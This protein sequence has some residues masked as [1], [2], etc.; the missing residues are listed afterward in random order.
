M[1]SD[2]SEESVEALWFQ[3]ATKLFTISPSQPG[4]VVFRLR[5]TDVPLT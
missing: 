1:A 2:S 5:L 3:T 4:K